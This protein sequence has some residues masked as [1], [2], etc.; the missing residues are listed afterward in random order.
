MTVRNAGM[1]ALAFFVMLV[2]C[3]SG[4]DAAEPT[5]TIATTT[6]STTP[7]L[8]R[9]GPPPVTAK[10]AA[11]TYVQRVLDRAVLPAGARRSESPPPPLLATEFQ[12]VAGRNVV[13]SHRLY[14]VPGG[15]L[16]IAE[17]LKA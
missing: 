1:V 10:A 9:S 6:T 4:H 7:D 3:S 5:S 8:H 16:A 11:V 2:G 15:A 14:T 17:Y 13:H 12:G